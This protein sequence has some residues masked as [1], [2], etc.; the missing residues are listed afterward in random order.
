MTPHFGDRPVGEITKSDVLAFRAHLAKVPARSEDTTLSNRRIN[1]I[2]KPPRQILNEAADRFEFHTAFRN[3][4][5]LKHKRSDVQPFR[6]A[7][8]S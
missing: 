3:I 6:L 8:S 5:P 4:K 1:A 2:M 7:G